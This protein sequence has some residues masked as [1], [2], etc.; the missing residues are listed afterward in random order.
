MEIFG[1]PDLNRDDVI[2]SIKLT[3]EHLVLHV[4]RLYLG[5]SF[6]EFN[7]NDTF[8]CPGISTTTPVN[9][10]FN[11]Q[12]RGIFVSPNIASVALTVSVPQRTQTQVF[13][14]W[15]LVLQYSRSAI[16]GSRDVIDDVAIG[17]SLS[18]KSSFDFVVANQHPLSEAVFRLLNQMESANSHFIYHMFLLGSVVFVTSILLLICMGF[19]LFK[20]AFSF[21]SAERNYI[22]NLFLYI[23]K[24]AIIKLLSDEKFNKNVKKFK[25]L[26]N[27]ETSKDDFP[28]ST[29]FELDQSEQM[30]SV[31]PDRSSV[32]SHDSKSSDQH[33]NVADDVTNDNQSNVV[34]RSY[35]IFSFVFMIINVIFGMVLFYVLYGSLDN[36]TTVNL[37]SVETNS[38]LQRLTVLQRESS[39]LALRFAQFSD[40]SAFSDY[41]TLIA[42]GERQHIFEQLTSAIEDPKALELLGLNSYYNDLL[43]Y[44][45]RIAIYLAMLADGQNPVDSHHLRY[46]NY[47]LKNETLYEFNKIQFPI[48]VLTYSN[49]HDDA[50][51]SPE[52]QRI[53]SRSFLSGDV[54]WFY[55]SRSLDVLIELDQLLKGTVESLLNQVSSEA[56]T[57]SLFVL[58]VPI[59]VLILLLGTCGYSMKKVVLVRF[60]RTTYSFILISAFCCV[61]IIIF[62]FLVSRHLSNLSY[63][64]AVKFDFEEKLNNFEVSSQ[65]LS[66]RASV[67]TQFGSTV[68][69]VG[70]FNIPNLFAELRHSG[71]EVVRKY[72]KF[73]TINAYISAVK[74][75][76]HLE[77]WW[78]K[79]SHL[80][81]IS[82]RLGAE[83]FELSEYLK[84]SVEDVTWD[85]TSESDFHIQQE[86][87]SYLPSTR[88]YT[89]NDDDLALPKE[90]LALLARATVSGPKYVYI[91]D[92][93]DT[94][95]GQLRH[96]FMRRFIQS[97]TSLMQD[98]EHL[99]VILAFLSGILAISLSCSMLFL[100][101]APVPRKRKVRTS[102]KQSKLIW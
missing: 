36:F 28:A 22:V 81:L 34:I 49:N 41:W 87:Y 102:N 92:N 101:L 42:S 60:R 7:A 25:S 14:F 33:I 26:E 78:L 21:I 69:Y 31:H 79:A 29:D 12:L 65:D 24:A 66:Y 74:D 95:I 1:I 6:S 19:F 77:N 8:P 73:Q 93:L 40:M 10:L 68:D 90:E 18:V 63:E 56:D 61:L 51:L 55:R 86:I 80:Q 52:D 4:R 76:T 15:Q 45:E 2:Q 17:L 16:I 43:F 83:A 54:Y 85:I 70:Y 37:E 91:L 75:L 62:V 99:V 39:A 38:L 9:A 89:N 96:G 58:I 94:E 47:D 84:N 44:Y 98:V 30:D 100:Y 27:S 5:S 46:F 13:S 57:L 53:I 59:V 72:P 11:S 97:Y 71:T 67:F 88:L 50:L 82:L 35:L 32:D 23:P 64:N 3:A 48:N 20:R